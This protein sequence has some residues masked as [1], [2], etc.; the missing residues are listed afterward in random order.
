MNLNPFQG[1]IKVGKV[2]PVIANT[3]HLVVWTDTLEILFWLELPVSAKCY[4]NDWPN[5]GDNIPL[6]KPTWGDIRNRLKEA[7]FCTKVEW[8]S[9][10][11]DAL[12]R[13]H[14]NAN[15]AVGKEDHPEELLEEGEVGTTLVDEAALW[16][17][18]ENGPEHDAEGGGIL[19]ENLEAEVEEEL[20][21]AAKLAINSIGV[22]EEDEQSMQGTKHTS[23]IRNEAL[24]SGSGAK[25]LLPFRKYTSHDL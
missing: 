21:F 3:G 22:E 9:A 16:E 14:E 15:G 24:V 20:A 4:C 6:H 13:G 5:Q 7:Y 1:I 10:P 23:R 2:P 12:E 17:A 19:K 8:K 18:D 25:V 11:N